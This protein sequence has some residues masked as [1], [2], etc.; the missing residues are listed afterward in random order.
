MAM[1]LREETIVQQYESDFGTE[2]FEF[3]ISEY[4]NIPR[5]QGI[6]DAF[7]AVRKLPG[8]VAE[9][10]IARGETLRQLGL[11]MKANGI[12]KALHAF[13]T[14]TGLPEPEPVDNQSIHLVTGLYRHPVSEVMTYLNDC[15]VVV[16]HEGHIK[17]T[18]PSFKKPL[19]FAAIDCDL[20]AG[21]YAA[22]QVC[23]R[24][25]GKGGVIVLD[26][27]ETSWE[28]VT[29]AVQKWWGAGKKGWR[30]ERPVYNPGLHP[31]QLR[32]WRE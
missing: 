21:T 1:A 30:M 4:L 31:G 7:L 26:D 2:V 5:M 12:K 32:F 9:F 6:I 11:F 28:G 14:F 29:A 17:N 13:D 8:D 18:G 24:V 10:G 22:L 3:G 23:G 19:C 16:I 25:I 15:D 20:Y 27:Y